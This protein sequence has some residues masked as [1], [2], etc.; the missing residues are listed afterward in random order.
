MPYEWIDIPAAEGDA[1][2]PVAELHMWPYRSLLRRQFVQFIG[3]TAAL[4]ALPLLAVLGSPVVWALMPFLLAMLA[5]LW[6]A[7][8]RS[9][10]D[11]E[12]LEKL[13]IWPD[14]VT[15]I[16][17]TPRKPDQTWQ[18]NPHW[19]RV[20]LAATTGPVPNY[21]TLTGGPRDVEVGAF[22]SEDERKTL[23]YDIRQALRAA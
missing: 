22:L 13:R 5:G 9:Y 15:L 23:E 6:L 2:P 8:S 21:L 1:T 20:E 4:I 16:R 17:H 3:A 7:L 18:A 19:V 11:G 10:R 14:R 12:V